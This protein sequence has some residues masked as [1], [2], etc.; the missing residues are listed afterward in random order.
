MDLA[1]G[2][3]DF[4]LAVVLLF[5]D[6]EDLLAVLLRPGDEEPDFF[7]PDE[8][9]E[10][11]ATDFFG[12]GVDAGVSAYAADVGGVELGLSEARSCT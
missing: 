2:F 10:L 9:D 11:D 4:E 1:A 6:P 5:F 3:L 12:L 8:P 7:V